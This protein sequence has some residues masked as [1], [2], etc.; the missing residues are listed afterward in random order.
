MDL[1]ELSKGIL[2]QGAGT[3]GQKVETLLRLAIMRGVS[4]PSRWT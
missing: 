3:I 2:Y 1:A 4:S